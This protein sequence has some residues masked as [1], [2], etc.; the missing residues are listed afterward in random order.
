MS[1]VFTDDEII[2]YVDEGDER[3]PDEYAGGSTPAALS[4]PDQSPRMELATA[5]ASAIKQ[6]LDAERAG[7][8]AQKRSA[9]RVT[10]NLSGEVQFKTLRITA[11]AVMITQEK[12]LR[13]D[14]VIVNQGS[15]DVSIGLH[16][17]IMAS[18]TDTVLIAGGGSR[19]IRT[20]RALW[21]ICGA[22]LS[23]TID[24]QEEFD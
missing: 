15:E 14:T 9:V 24:T 2:S 21:A 11:Q 17:G 22:G 4:L 5:L 3:T 7:W 8:E 6:V 18:G 19:T 23:T 16:A 12:E 20:K 10:T 13:G 1:N